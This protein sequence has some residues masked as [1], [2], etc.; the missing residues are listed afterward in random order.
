MQKDPSLPWVH[1]FKTKSFSH[2]GPDMNFARYRLH[3][4]A[5]P[6]LVDGHIRSDWR[7]L[8]HVGPGKIGY[9]RITAE[10]RKPCQGNALMYLKGIEYIPRE[11]TL[12]LN[13]LSQLGML[14]NDMH[15]LGSKYFS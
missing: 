15:L 12:T 9:C 5:F 14:I 3:Q 11:I 10:M 7:F 4:S 6:Q 13:Y 2:C 8:V 1:K